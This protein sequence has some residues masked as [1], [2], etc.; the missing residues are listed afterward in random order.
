MA[1]SMNRQEQDQEQEQ[2]P[3]RV[4]E[5]FFPKYWQSPLAGVGRQCMRHPSNSD[6]GRYLWVCWEYSKIKSEEESVSFVTVNLVYM[7]DVICKLSV[8]NFF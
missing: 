5:V 8:K 7:P 4:E 1:P 3:E 2:V 6:I